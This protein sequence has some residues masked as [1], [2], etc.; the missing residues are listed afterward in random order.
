MPFPSSLTVTLLAEPATAWRPARFLTGQGRWYAAL[1]YDRGEVDVT[2]QGPPAAL[3]ELAA[4]LV[5]AAELAEQ[6]ATSP[7]QGAGAGVG[8]A[9]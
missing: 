2:V 1:R 6:A 8:G 5:A 3:R 4:A 9:R 7:G